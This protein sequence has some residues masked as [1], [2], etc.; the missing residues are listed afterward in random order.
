MSVT[1]RT[2]FLPAI[3]HDARR[4]LWLAVA[5]LAAAFIYPAITSSTSVDSNL[6]RVAL[7]LALAGPAA[8]TAVAAAAGRPLLAA[9]AMSGVGAY[10]SGYLAIH[11]VAVPVAI[12]AGT[13]AGGAAG[14]VCGLLGARLDAVAF[15][16]LTLL[17]AIAA[18][19]AVQA[20]PQLLGAEAGLGPL[21]SISTPLGGHNLALLTPTGDF[22]VLLAVATLGTALA[23][24]VLS[25]GPGAAWRAVGSDRK[26][27]ADTGINVLAAEM[28]VL[29]FTGVLAG[30]SG[31]LAAHVSRVA[32]PAGFAADVAALPLLAALAAARDPLAAAVVA[33]GTGL[34]GEL[35]LPAVHWQGPPDSKSLALAVLA[36]AALFTLLPSRSRGQEPAAPAIDA[37]TPW[38]V[39]DLGLHGAD[40]TVTPITVV[41][42]E[43]AE[44]VSAP[45]FAVPSGTI[46]ALVGPNGSGKTTLLHAIEARARRSGSGVEAQSRDGARAKVLLLS[47][48]GGGF[49]TCTV[50]ETLRLAARAGRS[51]R[52][53]GELA[54]AWQTRLGLDAQ[55]HRLCVEL[56]T[57][58]RRLLDLARVLL[59]APDV[60]LC[61]E[62]LAGLDESH[63]AAARRCLQ[64]AAA[65]G[66]TIVL[67]EHDRD[68]VGALASSVI[69]LTRADAAVAPRPGA[70]GGS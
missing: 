43:G 25:R 50:A 57:G 26:R 5:A 48:E 54:A 23:A 10:V 67:A 68:A 14:A 51:G 39:E 37:D 22:H 47:Q 44:L 70:G 6:D 61:D 27:A 38:P 65:A 20:L 15:L 60:L 21:P 58:Q 17:L 2:R 9:A 3:P 4:L 53:G 30:I 36:V 62:P 24:L 12:L 55:A 34:V 64:A 63:R 13:A 56:S 31:A 1:T 19:A 45:E 32:T 41:S 40:L 42:P 16:V 69:E 11:G 8:G 59:T 66:L 35:L 28:A 49:A 29:V 18:G 46:T 7:A 33:V 52:A